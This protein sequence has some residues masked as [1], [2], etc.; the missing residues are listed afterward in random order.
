[1]CTSEHSSAG[2]RHVLERGGDGGVVVG[3]RCADV[4]ILC[5]V[6]GDASAASSQLRTVPSMKPT[7]PTALS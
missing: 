1:M 5:V 2:T 3:E 6:H 4:R 7:A